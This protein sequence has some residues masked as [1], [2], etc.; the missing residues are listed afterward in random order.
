[1]HEKLAAAAHAI[2]PHLPPQKNDSARKRHKRRPKE[3]DGGA[4]AASLRPEDRRTLARLA[5]QTKPRDR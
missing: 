5:A 3:D 1:V 2:E 4:L